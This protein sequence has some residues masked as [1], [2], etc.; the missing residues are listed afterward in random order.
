ME[1]AKRFSSFTSLIVALLLFTVT[2]QWPFGPKRKYKNVVRVTAH[3]YH[4]ELKLSG[5]TIVYSP[6]FWTLVEEQ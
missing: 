1:E 3:Q 6:I 5:G 4:Y 2:V